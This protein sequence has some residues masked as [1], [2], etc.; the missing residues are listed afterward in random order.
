M[1]SYGCFSRARFT[2]DEIMI[3][4]F[5]LNNNLCS[6]DKYVYAQEKDGLILRPMA[7]PQE[8]PVGYILGPGHSTPFFTS[9]ETLGRGRIGIERYEGMGRKPR[10]RNSNM[11]TAGEMCG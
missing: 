6:H 1:G 5:P 4:L 11:E 7:H 2:P 8:S 3:S 10:S 9:I